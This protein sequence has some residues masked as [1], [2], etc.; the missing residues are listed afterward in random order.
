MV[1]TLKLAGGEC[2]L[3]SKEMMG[4]Y[5]LS[6]ATKEKINEEK[7]K[8]MAAHVVLRSD[9]ARYRT[10]LDDLKSSANRER[11]E[12]PTTLTNDYDLLVRES[13]EQDTARGFPPRFLPRRPRGGPRGDRGRNSFLFAQ[14]RR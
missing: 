4:K 1:E 12:C 6:S 8:F 10:L 2:V 13:G 11:D 9:D 5:E 3:V 7:E 14:K